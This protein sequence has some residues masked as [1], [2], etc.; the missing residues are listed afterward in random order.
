MPV[1]AADRRL[2]FEIAAHCRIDLLA[3]EDYNETI[4]RFCQSCLNERIDESPGK[5]KRF[6]RIGSGQGP[7][8]RERCWQT[9]CR[10]ITKSLAEIF[11]EKAADLAYI[12]RCTRLRRVELSLYPDGQ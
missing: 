6:D 8:S 7:V 3:A 10:A 5:V 12:D 4:K 1:D 9:F 11:D 2:A